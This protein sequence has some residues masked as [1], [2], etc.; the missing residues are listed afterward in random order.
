MTTTT[1]N[2]TLVPV[3]QNAFQ[4]LLD[5]ARHDSVFHGKLKQALKKFDLLT[6][7]QFSPF[8]P[9]EIHVDQE[10]LAD[11]RY[12]RRLIRELKAPRPSPWVYHTLSMEQKELFSGKDNNEYLVALSQYM[13]ENATGRLGEVSNQDALIISRMEAMDLFHFLDRFKR[14]ELTGEDLSKF[15]LHEL[16]QRIID[17]NPR[18]QEAVA[19][20]AD[21]AEEAR[22]RLREEMKPVVDAAIADCSRRLAEISAEVGSRADAFIAKL[23]QEQA[24]RQERQRL[25]EEEKERLAALN[26]GK[27]EEQIFAEAV[28]KRELAYR[29]ANPTHPAVKVLLWGGAILL[30]LGFALF[31][32]VNGV[33]VPELLGLDNE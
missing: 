1:I 5:Q 28:K 29:Q 32:E 8:K 9:R 24:E 10:Q 11:S 6:Y 12:R 17:E 18:Y 14:F 25:E 15:V 33:P 30:A 4:T 2:N 16:C 23:K 7:R 19:M 21:A 20:I 22:T 26:A 27:S 31:G 3:F 13:A